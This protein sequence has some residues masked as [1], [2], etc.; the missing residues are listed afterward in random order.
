MKNRQQAKNR[1]E[2]LTGKK[3]LNLQNRI[4][5]LFLS[6]EGVDIYYSKMFILYDID[7][8]FFNLDGEYLDHEQ[9]SF[10]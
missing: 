2:S 9:N 1:M 10:F 4:R 6:V 3:I 7:E 5:K 8:L